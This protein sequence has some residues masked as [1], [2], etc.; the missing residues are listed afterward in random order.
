[1]SLF[2]FKQF[3]IIQEKSAM[4]VGT[5]AMVFGAFLGAHNPKTALDIGTG[6]GVL[7][8]MFAQNNPLTQIVALEI[9][10]KAFEEAKTNFENSSFKNQLKIISGN[11]LTYDFNQQFDFIFSNPPFFENAFLSEDTGRNLARHSYKMEFA[12]FFKKIASLLTENGKCSIILPC[13]L[14]KQTEILLKENNLF[15]S[16]LITVFGK[17]KKAVRHIYTFGKQELKIKHKNFTIRNDDGAYTSE[18]VDLTKEFHYNKLS[19]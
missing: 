6:T 3:N 16:E 12:K 9:E 2:K 10:A 14:N 15:V 17:T 18:Y 1:M 4:K 13:D 8:L 5:D 19:K 11:F 7:S